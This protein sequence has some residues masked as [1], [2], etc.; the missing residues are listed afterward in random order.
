MSLARDT[1]CLR[2]PA[3]SFANRFFTCHLTV[4]SWMF[5]VRPISLFDRLRASSSSTSRSFG[6]SAVE[7]ATRSTSAWRGGAPAGGDA[8]RGSANGELASGARAAMRTSRSP[9]VGW[10]ASNTR[11][12]P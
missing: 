4:S 9:S 5:I 8:R 12:R 6:V 2:V 7:R 3:L 11:V 1:T 10:A